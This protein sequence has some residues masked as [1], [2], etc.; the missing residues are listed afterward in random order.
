MAH[1]V[2]KGQDCVEVTVTTDIK[3]EC[4]SDMTKDTSD[5]V[6]CSDLYI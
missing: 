4:L 1:I 2:E 3:E 5:A 6:V